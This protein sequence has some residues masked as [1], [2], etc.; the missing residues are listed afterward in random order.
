MYQK[1]VVVGH[2]GKDP[3]M[4]YTPSGEAVTDFSLATTRKWKDK[5]GQPQEKTTWFKVTAWGKLAETC[6]QYL[7]KGK[8]VLVEG[9][10]EASAWTGQDGTPR[11]TL[12]LTARTM[13]MLG[14]A[15]SGAPGAEGGT[16]RERPGGVEEEEIPF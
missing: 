7:N 3:V 16:L 13:R 14:G 4:R 11:A 2:L 8:L 5:D 10:V 1:T 12:E 15:G 6:N 9:E